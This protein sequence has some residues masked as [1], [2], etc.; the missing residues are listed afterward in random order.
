MVLL[1]IAGLLLRSSALP[2]PPMSASTRAVSRCCRSIRTWCGIR[3]SRGRQ[4]WEDAVARA[5]RVPGVTHV[6]LAAPRVPFELNFSNTGF[7]ADDRSY[8]ADSR[9]DVLQYVSVSPGYFETLGVSIV[10]GRDF[11]AADRE[12]MPLVA[13]VSEALARKYWP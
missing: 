3:P 1:V 2:A 11:T 5:S 10:R 12:G 13:I 8:P 9:G 4:F 7:R 6:A